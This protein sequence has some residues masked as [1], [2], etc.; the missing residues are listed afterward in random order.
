MSDNS[1]DKPS[2]TH[3]SEVVSAPQQRHS[4]SVEHSNEPPP[5]PRDAL[6][7]VSVDGVTHGPYTGHQIAAFVEEDRLSRSTRVARVGAD[8]WLEAGDDPTLSDLFKEP[9]DE[10]GVSASGGG[11]AVQINQTIAPVGGV[12]D[13]FGPKSPGVALILSLLICGV[14][15]IYN[16]QIAKGIL[17]FI[18]LI[19]MIGTG[20]FIFPIFLAVAIW[21]WSM[22]DAYHQ[23]KAI[24]IRY[25][26]H[27]ARDANVSA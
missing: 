3:A 17:M 2:T 18:G 27:L 8:D 6:W 14:G 24:N 19:V 15:Q 25:Q 22:V 4:N 9:K 11:A 16:G 10:S 20:V 13:E 21:I 12:A 7:N 1:N 26:R 5:H 23:A